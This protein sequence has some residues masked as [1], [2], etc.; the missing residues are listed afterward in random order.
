VRFRV[1][2]RCG[3]GG[4]YSHLLL[5][6]VIVCPAP[7]RSMRGS[8]RELCM[9]RFCRMFRM[10]LGSTIVVVVLALLLLSVF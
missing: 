4:S 10:P 6:Q 2:W 1:G 5:L 7:L 3:A 9:R 8:G